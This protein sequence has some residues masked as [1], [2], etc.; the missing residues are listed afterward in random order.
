MVVVANARAMIG[1]RVAG[2]IVSVLPTA[3]GKMIFARLVGEAA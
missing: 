1:R 2:E 3:G